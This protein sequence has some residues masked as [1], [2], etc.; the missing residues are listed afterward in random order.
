M[1]TIVGYALPFRAEREGM[2]LPVAQRI[3]RWPQSCEPR[4][5]LRGSLLGRFRSRLLTG[6]VAACRQV[7]CNEQQQ[8]GAR[9]EHGRAWKALEQGGTKQNADAGK[10]GEHK[11]GAEAELYC[12]D[13]DDNDEPGRGTVLNVLGPRWHGGRPSSIRVVVEFNPTE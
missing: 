8:Y 9:A 1:A 12:D 4:L 3:G 13:A 2:H 5:L 10:D 6:A 7:I 11:F